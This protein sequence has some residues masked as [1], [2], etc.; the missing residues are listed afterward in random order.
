MF[1]ERIARLTP[2]L[3]REI[4]A[5][6]QR[7]EVISFAG[8]LPADDAL[9][10]PDTA[11]IQNLPDVWQYGQSEG[12]WRLR[13]LVAARAAAIGLA[14]RPEQVLILNGSQQGIDLVAKLMVEPGTP[15]LVEAPAY[16]AALQA[17][18]LFGAEFL[19][20]GVD[21]AAGPDWAAMGEATARARLSYLTPTF[22]N[23]SG[24]CYSAAERQRAAALLDASEG[25]V[26]EDDPYRDLAYD[27]AAPAPLVAGL[28]R[29]RW[30]YQGSFSK[31]LAP[32]LRLGYLIAHP[33]LVVPLTR[34]KQAADLHSNRLS[35]HIV[36]S[37]LESGT[38][39]AHV[40]S[41]LPGYRARRDAM[42]AS[43][44]RHF[45][46]RVRWSLPAGGLFFW[47]ALPQG[48]DSMALMRAALAENVAVMPGEAFYP[49]NAQQGGWL[50]L[51]FSHASEARIDAGLAQLA[52]L[53]E[54]QL[55][56]AA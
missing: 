18:G 29:A 50:R 44:V 37:V 16:L 33:G 14:C 27:G 42:A 21:P 40:A 24:Y 54:Q 17:F 34:L 56:Q 52:A 19:P 12:E 23:P 4:L 36:A 53:V 1:A 15:V 26:F 46:D 13:E 43:L 28:S 51:N 49:A 3:V 5:V 25:M 7:P 20:F 22:Q 2:S 10:R 32:G 31:T 48:I 45:G 30:V 55:R 35:Q 38:L 47:V 6:T 8:G 41:I 39:D 11:L 9:F